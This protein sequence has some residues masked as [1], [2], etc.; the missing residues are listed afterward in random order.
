[1]TVAVVIAIRLIRWKMWRCG[2]RAD[3][4][5]LAIGYGWLAIGTFA[6]GFALFLEMATYVLLHF[7]TVGALGTLSASVIL[8]SRLHQFKHL[9]QP[10]I[11]IVNIL[12]LLFL[13]T[14]FRVLAGAIVDSSPGLT[15]PNLLWLSALSWSAAYFALAIFML[16]TQ[17]KSAKQSSRTISSQ[18]KTSLIKASVGT[19]VPNIKNAASVVT[20]SKRGQC[21]DS[22]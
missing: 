14:L 1:M 17:S 6:L 7:I 19:M 22:I 2:D 18:H 21:H 13:A 5:G 3:L 12:G 20:Q 9:P 8:K 10:K 15:G 11:M 16:S 4:I